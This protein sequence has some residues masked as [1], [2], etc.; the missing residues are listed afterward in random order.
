MTTALAYIGW[1]IEKHL[2]EIPTKLKPT[3]Q[4]ILNDA[5][6]RKEYPGRP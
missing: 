5:K 4:E 6:A 1:A 3:F 2:D